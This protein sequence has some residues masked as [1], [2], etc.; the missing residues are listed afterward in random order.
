[1]L[2][3]MGHAKRTKVTASTALDPTR[4]NLDGL[5]GA[6]IQMTLDHKH[7]AKTH[8]GY[9]YAWTAAIKWLSKA[10]LLDPDN[11]IIQRYPDFQ[12]AFKDEP[13]ECSGK[14][15]ALYIT[16]KCIH[17]NLSKSTAELI[18]AAMKKYWEEL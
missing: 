15:L 3:N 2:T 11:E 16:F 13:K 9:G 6:R 12:E 10:C 14:A 18:H 4:I 5:D 17:K 1:M 8:L 7:A